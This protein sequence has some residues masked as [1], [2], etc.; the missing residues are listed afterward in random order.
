MSP[1]SIR[2]SREELLA[3]R[4]RPGCR[5][6]PPGLDSDDLSDLQESCFFDKAPTLDGGIYLGPQRGP[7]GPRA[8]FGAAARR[9]A[10]PGPIHS[11]LIEEE[12]RGAYQRT[13][14]GQL[15]S[16]FGSSPTKPQAIGPR[17]AP[18]GVPPS[19]VAGRYEDPAKMDRWDSRKL[20]RGASGAED[21]WQQAKGRGDNRRPALATSGS[22]S[23]RRTAAGG[24][25]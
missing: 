12:E 8:P 9:P 22:P 21:N 6:L 20:D 4:D 16:A 5:G 24:R 3:L 15:P 25:A 1:P 23:G 11:R 7:G 14:S 18:P 2:Y 13:S 19:P 17:G 10:G